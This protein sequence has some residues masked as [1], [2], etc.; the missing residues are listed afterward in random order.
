M[1]ITFSG[2]SAVGKTQSIYNLNI[3]LQHE[4]QLKTKVFR[5]RKFDL[6]FENKIGDPRQSIIPNTTEIWDP[7]GAVPMSFQLAY[8]YHN[9]IKPFM[10]QHPETVVMLDCYLY[11]YLQTF[12]Y[13]QHIEKFQHVSEFL[14]IPLQHNEHHKH[15]YLDAPITT[16]EQRRSIREEHLRWVD[17]DYETAAIKS[18]KRFCELGY[19]IEIDASGSESETLY[20]ICE[21]LELTGDNHANP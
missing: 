8:T 4:Y 18:Y 3:H 11:E 10:E 19:L 16:I 17:W 6:E 9:E 21:H 12:M 5:E 1:F 15:F 20:H 2:C 7:W 13:F 14:E